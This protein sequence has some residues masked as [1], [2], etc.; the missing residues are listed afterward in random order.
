MNIYII[1][2]GSEYFHL[3]LHEIHCGAVVTTLFE[4]FHRVSR[5]RQR[6]NMSWH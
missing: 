5:C 6:L 4:E 2:H 3:C 1:I